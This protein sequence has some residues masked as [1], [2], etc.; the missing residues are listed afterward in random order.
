LPFKIDE[1]AKSRSN[2]WIPALR[3]RGD[4]LC[5]GT[6]VFLTN[7]NFTFFCHSRAG[8]NPGKPVNST[9]YDTVKINR[10]E[11]Q[12]GEKMKFVQFPTH[13]RLLK[14]FIIVGAITLLPII[15]TF[16]ASEEKPKPAPLT[17]KNPTISKEELAFRVEP[18]TKNDLMVEADGW[19][20]VLKDHVGAVSEVQIQALTAE[21]ESKTKLLESV[22]LLKEKQT[23][24]TDRLKVVIE[25]LE[26]KGGKTEDY[27]SYITA[28]S[29]VQVDVSDAGATWTV[30][31]GWLKS[32]EGGLRWAKNIVF[33]LLII[34]IA[35]ILS[36]VVS[37]AVQ[38]AISN[39]K[40][41]SEL[42]KD[43]IVNITRKAIFLVGFIV[44]LSMLEVNVGPLLAVIGAAGFIMGFALQGTLSNFAA[45]ILILIYR[46]YDVGHLVDVAG[47][48]G[49]VDAM[50]I[51]STTLRK[52]D[53]QKIVVPNNMIWGDIITNITGTSK[54]RVDL[55]F[56]IGYSDNI[57]K[58]QKIL[59]D[60]LA[61][62]EFILKDPA[63]VVKVH[64]LADS[65]VNFIVRPWVKTD[66]YWDVYWDITRAVK[67]HFDAEG[68]SIPFPQRDIHVH[69]V[70]ATA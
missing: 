13:Q 69:Q 19:L 50:T 31:T 42:L 47:T 15:G 28:I 30:I 46:P 4:L 41:A 18:L 40:S 29:G 23:A 6:T 53:N 68:V 14:M 32:T 38:K 2:V 49:K 20:Q 3:L 62:H 16:A 67:E 56:G 48:F 27:G 36:K 60:I 44:A 37:K 51:V 5:A 22:N 24:L 55:V 10:V 21:G 11:L 61:G 63:P 17:T 34:F 8:G 58:A 64:E 66:N 43:F 57:A 70:E 26:S 9:F 12:K 39:I 7:C 35:L 65:S 59:E 52:P 54:R 1:L 33:F 45:G 25:E